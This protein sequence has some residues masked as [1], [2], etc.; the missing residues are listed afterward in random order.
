M[1]K[2]SGISHSM[3]NGWTHA[4]GTQVLSSLAYFAQISYSIVHLTYNT[5][6]FLCMLS[7]RSDLSYLF[8]SRMNVFFLFSCGDERRGS[9][10]FSF[11]FSRPLDSDDTYTYALGA[12]WL[13]PSAYATTSWIFRKLTWYGGKERHMLVRGLRCYTARGD[14]NAK[15]FEPEFC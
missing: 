6:K 12:S 1:L 3:W 11:F 13:Q 9:W 2:S 5:R 14:L 15:H 7:A 4:N 10:E 8:F